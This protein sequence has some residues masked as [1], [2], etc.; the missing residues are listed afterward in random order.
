[1]TCVL[2]PVPVVVT[3][4]GELFER[5]WL[6]STRRVVAVQVVAAQWFVPARASY[7]D[8]VGATVM[9]WHGI[10]AGVTSQP[11]EPT[12]PGPGG[13]GRACTKESST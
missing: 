9:A 3:S 8:E 2:L 13:A 5:P 12:E 11:A 7:A 6:S 4:S 1:M 10:V